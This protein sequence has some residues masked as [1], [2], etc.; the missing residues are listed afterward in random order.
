MSAALAIAV[1]DCV[2]TVLQILDQNLVTAD[3]FREEARRTLATAGRSG[4]AVTS[5]VVLAGCR[6]PAVARSTS[7]RRRAG[8]RAVASLE[9]VVMVDRIPE[10]RFSQVRRPSEAVGNR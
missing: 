4:V 10:N 8:W 2:R 1:R 5:I 3:Y 7:A 6:P 9:H